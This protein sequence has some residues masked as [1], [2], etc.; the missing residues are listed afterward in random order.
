[1]IISL[2]DAKAVLK[3]LNEQTPHNDEQKELLQKKKN[4]RNYVLGRLQ[5]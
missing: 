1:M 4:V 3:W 5:T 2:Q